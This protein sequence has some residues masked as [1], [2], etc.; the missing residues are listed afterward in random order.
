MSES[1][2]SNLLYTREHEWVSRDGNLVTIGITDFAQ[3]ELGDIVFVEFPVVGDDISRG[4]SFGVAESI[5]T[6]SDLYAPVS[7]KVTGINRAIDESP[8]LLNSDPYKGGWLIKV[9]MF[10]PSQLDELMSA[11]EYKRF[12]EE[13]G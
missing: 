8:S 10:D 4:D 12:I 11:D 2:P 3:G 13:E 9:E 5:K 7:G 1:I 6:V